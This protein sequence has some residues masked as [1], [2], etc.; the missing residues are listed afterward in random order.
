M[1]SRFE[2]L[3]HY[4]ND[5]PLF[6]LP[7]MVFFPHTVLPL[8]IFEPRYRDMVRDVQKH[9][10]PVVMGNIDTSAGIDEEGRP[11]VLPIAGVGFLSR[12]E[13]L[14][15]GRFLIELEGASRVRITNEHNTDRSYRTVAVEVLDSE[16]GD[17]RA[18][19]HARHSIQ[20]LAMGLTQQ[21][22][23][24]GEYLQYLIRKAADGSALADSMAAS[25]ITDPEARQALLE[26]V[27]VVSRLDAVVQRMAELMALAARP[28]SNTKFN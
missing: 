3:M 10:W 14:P 16:D 24:V 21:N 13:E 23:R 20:V 26:N 4:A 27:D 18:L 12:C 19:E 6:P 8:H 15:D 5:L 11:R 22:A 2:A 1:E 25:I 17:P 9:G 7:Q 28:D